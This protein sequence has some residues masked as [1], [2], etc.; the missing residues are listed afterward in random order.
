MKKLLTIL[1][2]SIFV[3]AFSS[4]K[5]DWTCECIDTSTNPTSDLTTFPKT[6]KKKAKDACDLI[7]TLSQGTEKCSLK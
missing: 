6:S 1:A 7:E 3:F 4:C 5:K 2:L